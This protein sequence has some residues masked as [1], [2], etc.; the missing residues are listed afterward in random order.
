M[1][2]ELANKNIDKILLNAFNLTSRKAKDIIRLCMCLEPKERLEIDQLVGLMRGTTTLYDASI[3]SIKGDQGDSKDKSH[4]D[5]NWEKEL[6]LER[7]KEL[8]RQ[9]R[10][11]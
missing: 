2:S 10:E 11:E 7:V 1:K 5:W 8:I 4:D 9:Q 6:L 3:Q